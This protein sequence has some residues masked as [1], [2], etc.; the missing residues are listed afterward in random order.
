MSIYI[1]LDGDNVGTKLSALIAEGNDE[2]VSAFARGVANDMQSYANAIEGIGGRILL[3]SGDS[4]LYTIEESKA[5]EAIALLECT[6]CT[7]T[8][9]VGR[10]IQEAH[11]C[12][13]YGKFLGKNC[14]HTWKCQHPSWWQFKFIGFF[15]FTAKA[16][17]KYWK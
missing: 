10:T 1:A 14:V 16:V 9:G 12:L 5:T 6:Y 11:L 2:L 17:V 8:I 13:N 7:F 4:V 3:C 15:Q